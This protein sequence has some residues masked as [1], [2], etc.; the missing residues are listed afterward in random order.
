MIQGTV[1]LDVSNSA[2]SRS[3]EIDAPSAY[4]C[5]QERARRCAFTPR[6]H[7]GGHLG[8]AD[9]GEAVLEEERLGLR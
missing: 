7:K 9:T 3:E 5:V 4:H 6:S 2:S 1:Q 8:E